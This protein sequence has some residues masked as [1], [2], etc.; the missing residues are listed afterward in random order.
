MGLSIQLEPGEAHW[1]LTLSGE[2]DYSECAPFRTMIDRILRHSPPRTVVD[3]TGLEYM[4]SSG[5]GLLLSLSKE[6]GTSGGRLI[7]ITNEAVDNILELTRLAAIFSRAA[8][9]DEAHTML[10]DVTT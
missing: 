5:L 2:L 8:S 4:D 3:L 6:Y 7:L 9:L 1:T 10:A